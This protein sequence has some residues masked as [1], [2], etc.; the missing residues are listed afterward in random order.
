MPDAKNPVSPS[1]AV[2][3]EIS[4]YWAEIAE[5]HDTEKQVAFAKNSLDQTGV[6]LDLG[7]GSGRHAIRLSKMGYDVVGLDISH[8]LLKI[9]LAKAKEAESCLALVRADMRFLPFTTDIFHGVISL[10]STLGY[11]PSEDDDRRSLKEVART[12]VEGNVFLLDVFNGERMF[13]GSYKLRFQDLLFPLA[14]FSG[15][16]M[17]FRWSEYPSFYLLQRRKIAKSNGMLNDTWIIRD[18]N[19]KRTFVAKHMVRLYVSAQLQKLLLESGLR[20]SKIF[21]DYMEEGFSK[22]SKR[23]IIIAEKA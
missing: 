20:T 5:A 17:L 8:R 1:G 15:L 6:V 18:K 21:G 22:D 7:C 19:A 16:F 3:D 10:D 12:L 11:F 14:K 4:D 23:I 2:F 13:S 9:A